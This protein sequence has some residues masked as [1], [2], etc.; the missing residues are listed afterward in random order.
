MKWPNIVPSMSML[1][2]SKQI[3]HCNSFICLRAMSMAM[4]IKILPCKHS[5]RTSE[6]DT[7]QVS[8]TCI[9]SGS[10]P[11]NC[12]LNYGDGYRQTDGTNREQFYTAYFARI[13]TRYGQYNVSI[14]CFNELSINTS[15]ITRV[16]RRTNV[17]SK[18]L[19]HKTVAE[20][21][22]PTRFDLTT[23]DDFAFRHVTCLHLRNALTNETMKLVWRKKTLEIIPMHVSERNNVLSMNTDE[24]L[25]LRFR[26]CLLAN[27][28]INSSVT[29]WRCS[30]T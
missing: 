17:N 26:C 2:S 8:F 1:C 23:R 3:C 18:L 21:S 5:V 12:T 29:R 24:R 10:I 11:I 14:Q 25:S 28:C 7:G 20:T 30:R 4:S 22:S 15:M 27:I 16:V 19:I 6:Q 9:F 13:Y